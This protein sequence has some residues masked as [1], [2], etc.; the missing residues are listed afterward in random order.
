MLW[1]SAIRLVEVDVPV[2]TRVDV[3]L[4]E[5]VCLFFNDAKVELSHSLPT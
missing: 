3:T 2:T 5:R 4:R 1:K